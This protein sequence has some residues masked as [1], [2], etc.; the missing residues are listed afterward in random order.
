MNPYRLPSSSAPTG[1]AGKVLGFI[2]AVVV[3]A[4]ALMFSAVLLVVLLVAG[5]ILGGY[6]WWRTRTLRKQMREQMEAL[7][8]NAPP[9]GERVDPTPSARGNV[10]EG[11]AVR[12]DEPEGA[13]RG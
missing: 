10:F 4:L 5:L 6:F 11:E 9:A 13:P 7:R 3:G 2:L 12:V 8:R 1:I